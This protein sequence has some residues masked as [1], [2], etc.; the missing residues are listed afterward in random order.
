[1]AAFSWNLDSL[2]TG[3]ALEKAMA[4]KA[5]RMKQAMPTAVQPLPY[6]E[7]APLWGGTPFWDVW[8]YVC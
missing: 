1:M 7:R 2:R 5:D 3:D 6:V 8:T 4:L